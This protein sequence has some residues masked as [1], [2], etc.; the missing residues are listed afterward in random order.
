MTRKVTQSIIMTADSDQGSSG[1]F[2]FRVIPVHVLMSLWATPTG[3]LSVV[4]IPK[5]FSC[6]RLGEKQSW[7]SGT[8]IVPGSAR[9]ELTRMHQEIRIQNISRTPLQ[10]GRQAG[11]PPPRPGK[12]WAAFLVT[13]SVW[14]LMKHRKN[15]NWQSISEVKQHVH[16]ILAP[17]SS[18]YCHQTF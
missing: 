15:G 9:N 18:T 14:K 7:P 4:G 12:T 5:T 16:S 11:R 6:V 8:F 1:P 10:A 13:L 3:S 17:H 2:I